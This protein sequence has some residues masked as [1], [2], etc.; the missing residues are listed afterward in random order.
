MEPKSKNVTKIIILIIA[1]INEKEFQIFLNT[2][3]SLTT[4]YFQWLSLSNLKNSKLTK[5]FWLNQSPYLEFLSLINSN[6]TTK[7]LY[8]SSF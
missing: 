8:K 6:H 1:T 3:K 2:F 5:I 4:K 7:T